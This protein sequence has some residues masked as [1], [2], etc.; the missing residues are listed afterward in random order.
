MLS[1]NGGDSLRRAR[2]KIDSLRNPEQENKKLGEKLNSLWEQNASLTSQNHSLLSKLESVQ[3]E[4]AKSKSKVRFYGSALGTRTSRLPELQEQIVS[5]KAESEVQEKALRIAEDK[6]LESHCI[7]AEKEQILQKFREEVKKMKG[8]LCESNKL[9]K[10]AERQRNEALLN[11]EELTRAFQQYKKNVAE[12]LER[13]QAEGELLNKNFQYCEKERLE[14]QEKCTKLE[15]E[16]GNARE[17]LRNLIS[18]KTDEQEKQKCNE[19]KNTELISLLTQSNQRVLRL[20]SE[21]E[22]KEKVLEENRSLV[23]ETK[24]LKQRLAE[25]ED[26][27]KIIPC[28]S[29]S[30][31]VR[32][33]SQLK[34]HQTTLQ[35]K[36]DN[37]LEDV[38][39]SDLDDSRLLIMELRAQLSV[40]EAENREVQAKLLS[41][42]SGDALDSEPVKLS[43]QQIEAE[44]YL[45]L[46]T[47]GKQLEA[48][49]ERLTDAMKELQRKLGKAQ[50]ETT[51]T[52]LSM[53]Q[54]T[55]QFQLIQEELLEKASKTTKLEQEMTKK[56]LKMTSLQRLLEEKTQA[57]AS[58]ADRNAELEQE[59]MDFK[60]Q[61]HH[62]E[63]SIS[64]EHREVH[65]AFEKSK[66]IHLIQH[67]ELLKQIEQL[68]CQLEMKNLQVAEHE[69]TIKTLQEDTVSTQQQLESLDNLLIE[70]RREMDL[71]TK[72]TADAMKVL[73]KQVE[74]ETA[75]VR[76][77]ET[78]LVV[79]KEELGLYLQQLEDNRKHFENQVKKKAEEVLLLQKEIKLKT[80]SLQDTNEENLLLQQ[81]LQQQQQMLQQGN[82]RI[83][84]LEE[85]QGEL[86]KQVSKLEFKLEKH[87]STSQ[88]EI[89][90]AEGKLQATNQELACKSH[91]VHELSKTL[92]QMKCEFE[93]CKESLSQAEGRLLSVTVDGESKNSKMSQLELTLQKTQIE[94][95]DKAQL[96]AVLQE[97]VLGAEKLLSN[98]GEME[99]E[100]QRLREELQENVRHV[101][102]LQETLAKT[103]LSVEEKQGM[104]QA[105]TEELRT[106]KK[107]LEERDLELLDMD[108]ALKDRNWELKQRAAQLTQLDM[109]IR[110]HKGELQQKINQ[111]ESALKKSELET[112]GHIKQI[113]SLDEKLQE[114]REQLREQDFGLL[115]KDQYINQLQKEIEKKLLAVTEM[116]QTVKEQQNCISEQRQE[117]KDLGQQVQLAREGMQ[118]THLKLVETRQQLA[119]A[120]KES[121]RL[122]RKLEEMDL[123]SREKLQHLKQGLDDAQ[124]TI[125]NLKTELEARNE[126]I[127]ATNEVLILKESELT[128]LK[129]RISGYERSLV[130]KQHSNTV[131]V[132]SDLFSDYREPESCNLTDTSGLNWK[133]HGSI[134]DVGLKDIHPI[135]FHKHVMEDTKNLVLLNSP[136][137]M[138][139]TDQVHHLP[140]DSVSD[141]SFNPL[142]YAID[143]D[144]DR[145]SDCPDLGTLSCM[146]KY[147][148]QEMK[149]SEASE[150]RCQ[151]KNTGIDDGC[152]DQ[153]D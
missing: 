12:K 112:D 15:T 22:N 74:D 38:N 108:Q 10:R 142:E 141:T 54:R 60:S 107:E 20:E 21:L 81:T 51:K 132:S 97:R 69:F 16:L 3:L 75:K 62:L 131:S 126:V 134:S 61:I 58:A 31:G 77:L 99:L 48:E 65:L 44:K 117:G 115:Q 135:D 36:K 124:D 140:S 2:D 87:K 123:F 105:L 148:K 150:A 63:E 6:L 66:N 5:L 109:S 73:E 18:E 122:T 90:A 149:L 151:G 89:R 30:G 91:Q 144:C 53:A 95:D 41:A 33:V 101:E 93:L 100:L 57:Y 1:L 116:E 24:E 129:A 143:D 9:C 110:E 96:V 13:I 114:T 136:L 130:L 55:N 37:V 68:Q 106:C 76:Q 4:L 64:K 79:C 49:N 50:A 103:H 153:Q 145:T 139:T 32:P 29:E 104:I 127:K 152:Q 78:A 11:A 19:M 70:T 86:E 67:N 8:E 102:E 17:H 113:S 56:S 88:G 92:N 111:L 26:L 83:G 82:A 52:K 137:A 46:E 146:L 85:T 7:M 28:G 118:V 14:S 147:I 94:L 35:F 45:H 98:K 72:I 59:L 120:Q 39:K 84:D 133:I 138:S 80:Q 42:Y 119:E 25:I 71:Q 128:R 43:F 47:V 34:Y 121:D 27:K 40:K 125:C 23:H